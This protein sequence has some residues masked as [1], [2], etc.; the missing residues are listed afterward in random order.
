MA[1]QFTA[2]TAAAQAMLNKIVAA[3]SSDA[4]LDV[5]EEVAWKTHAALVVATPKFIG[6]TRRAWTVLRSPGEGYVVTNRNRRV[7]TW[8]EKGTQGP[9]RPRTAKAL[10]IPLTRSAALNGWNPQLTINKDYILRKS[11]KGIDAMW[12]VKKQKHKTGK[13]LRS[14]MGRYVDSVINS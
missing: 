5:L 14:A 12:I 13:M 1:I 2:K 10:F 7:M 3:M 8:L 6:H 9:I 4:V 11:V